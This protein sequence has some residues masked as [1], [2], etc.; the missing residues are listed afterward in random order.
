MLPLPSAAAPSDSII[1]RIVPTQLQRNTAIVE[2]QV[3]E[4]GRGSQSTSVIRPPA[5]MQSE[6][7]PAP[8]PELRARVVYDDP[9][10]REL[11]HRR[12]LAFN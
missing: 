1:R 10:L 7:D 11:G 5:S 4:V 12:R 3:V 6:C 2:G 8:R 9:Q